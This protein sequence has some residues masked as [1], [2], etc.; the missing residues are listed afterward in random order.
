MLFAVSVASTTKTGVSNTSACASVYLH[1][2][3][4]I[5]VHIIKLHTNSLQSVQMYLCLR[6]LFKFVS[7]GDEGGAGGLV[8]IWRVI[9]AWHGGSFLTEEGTGV[10]SVF[11]MF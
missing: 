2:C 4:D 5:S 11:S 10:L 3:F 7:V 1:R 8:V 9:V 6:S